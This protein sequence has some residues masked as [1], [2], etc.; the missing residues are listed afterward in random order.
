MSRSSS[1]SD[2]FRFLTAAGPVAALT[3]ARAWVD[4]VLETEAALAGAQADAGE[5]PL[6][7]A[8]GIARACDVA[9]YDVDALVAE[10]ALGGN[11]VIPLLP[12]LREIVGPDEAGFV[13]RG[14]TSQD[15]MDA[16]TAVVGRRC[17]DAVTSSLRRA[18]GVVVEIA[19]SH[20][21]APMIARTLG[22]HAVPTT[23]ATVTGRW[24]DGLDAAVHAL[25]RV[26]RPAVGLGGPSGD[27]TSFGPCHGAILEHFAARLDLTVAPIARHAQRTWVADI[28]GAWGVVAAAAG[29]MATDVVVLAQSEIA[30][31][32]E[33]APGAGG[34]SSM[35][36]KHNPIAAIS[37]RAA[38]MQ[39]P[40][41]VATVLT[42]TGAGELERAAGAWHAEWPALRQLWLASGS[43]VH[44]I[45]ESLGRLRV[46]AERMATNLARAGEAGHE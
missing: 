20:G 19:T 24:A 41:L 27:G 2:P 10:A 38:A 14:A 4:A 22:Q 34:S 30:E 44:W 25:E 40:G 13:H 32:A 29:K 9:R 42:A 31:L 3:S 36:H 28:A 26:A 7:A 21:A 18:S 46:D 33:V 6:G 45:G 17:A 8:G 1:P 43:A 16:A 37:A 35:P 5:I 39:V 23:F 11:L 15:V 12:R